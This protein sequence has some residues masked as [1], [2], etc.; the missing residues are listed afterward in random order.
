MNLQPAPIQIGNVTGY[1][2]SSSTTSTASVGTSSS[3]QPATITS[4][5]NMML[6]PKLLDKENMLLMI[7]L[8]ISSKPTFQTFT[9]NDSSVQTPDYDTKNVAPKVQLKSGQ[10]L[11]ITG[12]DEDSENA[13]KSGV[14]SASFFGLG[15]GRT[16]STTHS[17]M[18]VLVTPIVLPDSLGS[19]NSHPFTF[20]AEHLAANQDY[21]CSP[22]A[23]RPPLR[24][25]E[26]L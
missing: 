11:V 25:C 9:S 4:G 8:S 26:I 5:F 6:L 14:G 12:F 20:G 3:L 1:V 18:V 23:C 24:A 16:R 21:R 13:K 10:T 22:L 2:A 15:G 7:T 19:L 17:A